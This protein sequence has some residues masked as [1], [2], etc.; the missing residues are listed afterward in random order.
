MESFGLIPKNSRKTMPGK[1][2]RF[3]QKSG[4]FELEKSK[5]K[6]RARKEFVLRGKI[7]DENSEAKLEELQKELE[8]EALKR[9]VEGLLH[10]KMH[11]EKE[12]N[13]WIQF[14]KNNQGELVMYA[15]D[16]NEE[17]HVDGEIV[18]W[19]D[20]ENI[21]KT[22][23]GF[24]VTEEEWKSW[25]EKPAR[26]KDKVESGEKNDLNGDQEKFL[27]ELKNKTE[28]A[29]LKELERIEKKSK[30]ENAAE[31]QKQKI[32]R[33]I[34]ELVRINEDEINNVFN[35]GLHKK[36][37]E[38]KRLTKGDISE[39]N[40]KMSKLSGESDFLLEIKDEYGE[41][42][43]EVGA[44]N[45][46]LKR[47]IERRRAWLQEILEKYNQQIEKTAIKKSNVAAKKPAVIKQTSSDDLE[48]RSRIGAVRNGAAND[49]IEYAEWKNKED[50]SMRKIE[51]EEKKIKTGVV[52]GESGGEDIPVKVSGKIEEIAK[53]QPLKEENKGRK[54]EVEADDKAEFGD[55]SEGEKEKTPVP[56]IKSLGEL[57]K[58]EGGFDS[59]KVRKFNE[60]QWGRKGKEKTPEEQGDL[61]E[62]QKLETKESEIEKTEKVVDKE[63]PPREEQLDLFAVSAE[64]KEK[65]EQLRKEVEGTRKEYAETDYKKNK[66]YKRIYKFLFNWSEDKNR[67]EDRDIAWHRAH[68]DNKLFSYKNALIEDAK[69]RAVSNEELGEIVRLFEL[70]GRLNMADAHTQV[71]FENQDGKFLGF[72]KNHGQEMVSWY[73]SLSLKK[74]IA[75]GAAFGLATA[76][77]AFGISAAAG[78]VASVATVRRVFAGVVTGTT[79]SLALE[80][81][82]RKKAEK[83]IEKNTQSFVDKLN[84]LPAEG[85][86]KLVEDRIK[87]LVFRGDDE[88]QEIKNKNL[89]HLSA[90]ALAGSV[91]G[92]GA[93]SDV[94]GKGWHKVAGYFGSEI[95]TGGGAGK[96]I[97][98]AK[99]HGADYAGQG[100]GGNLKEMVGTRGI[101]KNIILETSVEETVETG[102][103]GIKAVD[104]APDDSRFP[105]DLGPEELSSAEDAIENVKEPE[106]SSVAEA[107]DKIGRSEL[108]GKF[109]EVMADVDGRNRAVFE[110]WSVAADA[111]DAHEFLI[112][113]HDLDFAKGFLE[114]FKEA[115]LS[116]DKESSARS[117][118]K[119]ISTGN[120]WQEIKDMKFTGETVRE[121]GW[122][123]NERVLETLENLNKIFGKGIK[124]GAQ[125][126]LENWTKRVAAI[127]ME[128]SGK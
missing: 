35:S 71:K 88:L 13:L 85:R 116:G 101:P 99:S 74:K 17:A 19:K 127:A 115:V 31:K 7:A 95:L 11:N 80:S 52:F 24:S 36:F 82:D 75:I 109:D 60:S 83:N 30:S 111:A 113:K 61:F 33:E 107:V 20:P 62:N 55:Q 69:T 16:E 34:S 108:A 106:M 120:D 50:E 118:Q 79:L 6:P 121:L 48:G 87:E 14:S 40:E 45:E 112:Q 65:L 59:E 96:T 66:A 125:E 29:A 51:G 53:V 25:A 26:A 28:A 3:D 84:E 91:V 92:S 114:N 68:Y 12:S 126:T 117:I 32:L 8:L 44:E 18:D 72:V 4:G 89:F 119:I 73:N 22:L 105:R 90:G 86:A 41:H 27:G 2:E 103:A 9:R 54:I 5:R 81:R 46:R 47:V 10:Q 97:E 122:R 78:A 124:P 23:L 100:Q 21:E 58:T 39:I 38:K 102:P 56:E 49:E 76:S 67:I 128:K 98:M 64:N 93:L 57:E 37:L 110:K 15:G 43:K 104:L 123:S 94:I 63:D 42:K 77:T 1:R 70:E